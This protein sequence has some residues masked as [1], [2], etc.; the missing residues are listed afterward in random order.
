MWDSG[1]RSES[2]GE[3]ITWEEAY[4]RFPEE[5][6]QMMAADDAPD[7]WVAVS[8]YPSNDRFGD[9]V[10]RESAV[11]GGLAL[12]AAGVSIAVVRVRR[13]I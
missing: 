13:P 5:L 2:T 12:L 4:E 11:F 8:K 7:G 9:S 3:T 6:D 10:L 1:F